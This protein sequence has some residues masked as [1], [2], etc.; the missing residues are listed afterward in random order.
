RRLGVSGNATTFVATRR[1]TML[2]R[3]NAEGMTMLRRQTISGQTPAS[4]ALAAFLLTALLPSE[5]TV[6]Q[7]EEETDPYAHLPATMTLNGTV[8]DFRDSHPDFERVPTGDYGLYAGIVQDQL[9]ADGKPVFASTG[10]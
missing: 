8:R 3:R 5:G 7:P 10:K 6:A 1:T 9:D 2:R 4:A